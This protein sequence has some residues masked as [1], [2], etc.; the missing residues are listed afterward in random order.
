MTRTI[1]FEDQ[2]QDFLE[3][4]ID[5][6][7]TV[8]ACRPAQA[9][10]WVGCVVRNRVI[11]PGCYIRFKSDKIKAHGCGASLV[12]KYQVTEFKIQEVNHA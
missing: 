3:W 12:L 5:L 11:K 6:S 8:I 4:D 1:T 2:G 7:N 9:F 10:L